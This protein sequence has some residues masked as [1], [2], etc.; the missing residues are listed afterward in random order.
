[1]ALKLEAE[2]IERG[3]SVIMVRTE[4][5]V[6]ISNSERAAV[7][8]EAKAD[9]FIRI[10]ANGSENSAVNGAMTIC[11]TEDNIYNGELYEESKALSTYVL[12]CLV[13]ETGCKKEYVW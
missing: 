12:D 13:E 7:A 5:D 8:N 10:H 9:V 1:M 4:N 11:Q 6:D 2:L 3:Y